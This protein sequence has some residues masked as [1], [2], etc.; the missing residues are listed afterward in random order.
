MSAP[1]TWIGLW[2]A[3]Y[4]ERANDPELP[5]WARVEFAMYGRAGGSD[6]HAPFAPGELREVL[7]RVDKATGTLTAATT[8]GVARAI[9]TAKAKGAVGPES[10]A[11]CLVVPG[12]H[13]RT[14]PS[15]STCSAHG[16]GQA[17]KVYPSGG[18]TRRG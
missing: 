4:M 3:P 16:S 11:R 18:M 2:Q 17:M 13:Y 7:R 9:R 6:G 5:D 1:A 15:V 14:G 8:Q 12:H 10:T